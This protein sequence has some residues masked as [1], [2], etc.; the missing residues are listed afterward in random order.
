MRNEVLLRK[1]KEKR[2]LGRPKCRCEDIT[3]DLRETGWE[4]WIC[5]G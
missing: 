1:P 5:S 4:V 2:A 3:M